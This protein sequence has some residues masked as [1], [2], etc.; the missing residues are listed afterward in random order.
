MFFVCEWSINNYKRK[1]YFWGLP[2]LDT[3]LL[4]LYSMAVIILFPP[5]LCTLS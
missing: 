4:K 1:T 3:I 5:C 2:L